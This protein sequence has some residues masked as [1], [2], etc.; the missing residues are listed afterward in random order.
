MSKQVSVAVTVDDDVTDRDW[1]LL[2]SE[3]LFMRGWILGVD[4]GGLEPE[5]PKSH[6]LN[7]PCSICGDIAIA[8]PGAGTTHEIPV[9]QRH[10]PYRFQLMLT[11]W[12]DGGW[13][14]IPWT[15]FQRY[16]DRGAPL[17]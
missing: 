6:W 16:L 7:D 8:Y 5:L 2:T 9:C 12:T 13:P 17:A 4:L 15:K 1:D 3:L 14:L 11:R 10:H